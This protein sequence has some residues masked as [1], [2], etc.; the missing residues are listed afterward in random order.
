MADTER[1]NEHM[2]RVLFFPRDSKKPMF[3][4]LSVIDEFD[5]TGRVACQQPQMLEQM[6]TD[7]PEYDTIYQN[8]ITS[9]QLGYGIH[10]CHTENRTDSGLDVNQAVLA[11][12][13]GMMQSPWRGPLLAFCGKLEEEAAEHADIVEVTDM[14]MAAYSH[15]IAHLI[16]RENEDK[17]HLAIKGPK[18]QAVKVLCDGDMQANDGERYTAGQLPRLHP[19]VRTNGKPME[20]SWHI[21]MLLIYSKCK[22]AAGVDRNNPAILGMCENAEEEHQPGTVVIFREDLTPLHVEAVKDFGAFCKTCYDEE[23]RGRADR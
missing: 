23:E 10:L 18:S 21:G 3:L 1:P 12:T 11:A 2:R 15:I 19:L 13:G 7:W 8:D 16:D 14:G 5:G 20:T 22:T 6:G 9:V 4:W 17:A